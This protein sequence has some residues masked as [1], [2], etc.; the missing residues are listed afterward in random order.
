MPLFLPCLILSYPTLW[1]RKTPLLSEMS[2]GGSSL[3]LTLPYP[4]CLAFA[5]GIGDAVVLTLSYLIVSYVVGYVN[6]IIVGD[7]PGMV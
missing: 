6:T 7:V 4:F 2:L 1:D 3:G 5:C